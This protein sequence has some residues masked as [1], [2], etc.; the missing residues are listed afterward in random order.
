MR[1]FKLQAMGV[2]SVKGEIE[3]RLA[4]I[5]KLELEIGRYRA[6]LSPLRGFPLEILG[7]VFANVLTC[8]DTPQE[9]PKALTALILVCKTWQTA[10][11]ETPRLWNTLGLTLR[12]GSHFD[13]AKVR[14]WLS[15]SGTLPRFFTI[16]AGMA[17]CNHFFFPCALLTPGLLDLFKVGPPIHRLIINSFS[18][19]C[20]QGLVQALTSSTDPPTQSWG[21]L[22]SIEITVEGFELPLPSLR[23]DAALKFPVTTL[24]L[25]SPLSS[26]ARLPGKGTYFQCSFANL[27]TLTLAFAWPATWDT[28]ILRLCTN[29]H[30]L[31]VKMEFEDW[32][33]D[34]RGD[35]LAIFRPKGGPLTLPHLRTLRINEFPPKIGWDLTIL[36]LF[37]TPALVELDVGFVDN[38]DS[39]GAAGEER[40]K[41]GEEILSL[42]QRSQCVTTLAHL[43]IASLTIGTHSLE[44]I[45]R[46]LPG[47]KHLVLDCVTLDSAFFQREAI[48]EADF[49]PQLQVLEILYPHDDFGYHSV[50]E[51][52]T[53]R[54]L[55]RLRVELSS[56]WGK[57]PNETDSVV[58]LRNKGIDAQVVVGTKKSRTI[59]GSL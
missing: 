31:S 22:N 16:D 10:A 5:H 14:K 45:L 36:R 30:T 27:A 4:G 53:S 21:S 49:L 6:L 3:A 55:Q 43:R 34:D 1:L 54:P 47:V 44:S 48:H 9:I 17:C 38:S 37:T 46:N 19:G 39:V 52:I 58:Y 56:D 8:V 26:P 18:N 12:H 13:F 15:K 35:E 24:N 51:F 40:Q 33:M 41:F 57:S 32:W 42:L 23:D 11:L 7:E 25:S 28:G 29:L 2:A 50:C 59:F 20:F